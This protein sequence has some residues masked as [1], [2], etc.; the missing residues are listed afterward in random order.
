MVT[1]SDSPII[2]A[3]SSALVALTLET[4]ALHAAAVAATGDLM[5]RCAQQVPPE[6]LLRHKN[7]DWG[8]LPLEDIRENDR[9][10]AHGARLF[11]S[12]HT[13]LDERLWIITEWDRSATT[14]LLPEEY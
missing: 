11:S 7:G 3:D 9:S 6:F 8:E 4:D 13:R 5:T 10:L 2:I 12:Y 1:P 14:L